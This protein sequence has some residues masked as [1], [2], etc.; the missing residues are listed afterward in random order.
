MKGAEFFSSPSESLAPS[1]WYVRFFFL[2][3]KMKGMARSARRCVVLCL[4][5]P[6]SVGRL[7][8]KNMREKRQKDESKNKRNSQK[9]RRGRKKDRKK[10]IYKLNLY[11]LI[12][13]FYSVGQ[14]M[15]NRMSDSLQRVTS[16]ARQPPYNHVVASPI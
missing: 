7:K 3:S 11:F 10:E 16:Y 15:K 9:K 8:K 14:L 2:R 6:T 13:K 12:S 5:H 1:P 4:L